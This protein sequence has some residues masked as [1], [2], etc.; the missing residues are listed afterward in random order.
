MGIS[1]AY[2]ENRRTVK[3]IGQPTQMTWM[4][5]PIAVIFKEN[6]PLFAAERGTTAHLMKKYT[7]IPYSTPDAAGFQNKDENL[8]LATK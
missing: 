2:A 4:I 1:Q 7:A 5:N 6:G 3:A 8:R